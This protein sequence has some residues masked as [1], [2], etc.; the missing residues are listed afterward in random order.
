MLAFLCLSCVEDM[1]RQ[2][3]ANGDEYETILV[4]EPT[5]LEEDTIIV[6]SN[7][8]FEDALVGTNAPDHVLKE[9]VLLD[10]LYLSTDNKIHKGQL[11]C[12]KKIENDIQHM[13]AFMLKNNFV[14]EKVIPATKY[15]WSDSLSMA[16]N[17]SH[18]FNYRDIS[19]SKHAYGMAIDIN[20]KFNP[21][22][23]KKIDKPNEPL[24]AVLD[25]TTNGTLHPN[26]IVVE[27]FKRLGF[28]WGH[29][30]SKYYDDH[31]FDKQ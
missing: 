12:N 7:L 18:S 23:W 26:H 17:N 9:L 4:E 29:V 5:T 22:R 20:P 31:H 15:D 19:Y 2:N 10:V 1:R 30:F 14:I 16:D 8:S 11:M 28:R 25:T 13:F 24:G 3:R 27:E 21:L 6:D